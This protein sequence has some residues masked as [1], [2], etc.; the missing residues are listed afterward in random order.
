MLKEEIHA[1]IALAMLYLGEGTKCQG[2]CTITF[3]NSNPIIIRLFLALL[4]KCYPIDESKFRC[5]IQCRADQNI[6]NLTHYWTSVTNIP[7]HQFYK[8]RID[9]R[10]IGKITMKPKYNG[11]CRIDYFSSAIY[12]DLLAA[13]DNLTM[14]S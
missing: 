7:L 11:V 1:K 13:I 6:E 12:L 5:T 2:R 14:G 8:S 3:G 10:T 9:K 4:R